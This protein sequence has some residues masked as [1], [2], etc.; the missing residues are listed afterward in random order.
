MAVATAAV[1]GLLTVAAGP[2]LAAPGVDPATVDRATVDRAANPGAPPSTSTAAERAQSRIR[3][4]TGD[5][6]YKVT[7]RGDAVIT[8]VDKTGNTSTATSLVAPPPK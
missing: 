2:A 5:I 1:T 4:G 7:L 3:D 8:G 6:D